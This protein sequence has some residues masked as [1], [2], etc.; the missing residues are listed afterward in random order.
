MQKSRG[1]FVSITVVAALALSAV[2][3]QAQPNPFPANPYQ[4]QKWTVSLPPN[5]ILGPV[6]AADPGPGGVLYVIN[7]CGG[8]NCI[9]GKTPPIL[10]L[11]SSGKLIKSWGDG[12]FVWPHGGTVDAQGNLWVADAVSPTGVPPAPAGARGHQVIKFSPE[13]EVLMRLGKA[14]VSG[15][16]PDTFNAP[17]DVAVARNGD[18]FVSDGHGPKTNARVVKFS[19]DGKFVKAWGTYGS[20]RDNFDGPHA[21][22]VDAKGRVYVADRGNN[23]VMVFDGDGNFVADWRQ[24]GRPSGIAIDRNGTIFV[25]DT[26]TTEG[27]P[28]WRNGIYIGNVNDGKVTAFIPKIDEKSSMEGVAIDAAGNVWGAEVD[29]QTVRKFS[30]P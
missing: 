24:F 2:A 16:G 4:L 27:R 19:R 11:D 28:G 6:V 30:K 14:G 20:G 10:K 25:T 8:E 17:T 7:R 12:L 29:G 15:T 22:A 5:V 13:G 21:I 9:T 1:V 26:Q 3:A 18:I 23:R